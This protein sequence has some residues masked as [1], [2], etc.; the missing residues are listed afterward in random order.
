MHR[1]GW[2]PT[3]CAAAGVHTELVELDAPV[4]VLERPLTPDVLLEVLGLE[5]L[6]PLPRPELLPGV[7]VVP[8]S[9]VRPVQSPIPSTVEH[10][11]IHIATL[12][13]LHATTNRTPRLRPKLIGSSTSD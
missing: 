6:L 7:E 2:L 10:P 11:P 3:H 4:L 13:M 8:P 5:P 12:P 1:C 9:L